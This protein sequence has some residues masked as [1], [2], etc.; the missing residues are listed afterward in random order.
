MSALCYWS[1]ATDELMSMKA[2]YCFAIFEIT[3]LNNIK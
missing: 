3:N 2:A 1:D